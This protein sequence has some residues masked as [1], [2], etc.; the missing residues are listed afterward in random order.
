M[1]RLVLAESVT[2]DDLDDLARQL[3]LVMMNIIPASDAH[4][5]QTIY[6]TRN[7]TDLVHVI[8]DPRAASLIIVVQGLD[9]AETAALLRK[10]V[11]VAAQELVNT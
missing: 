7:R 9:A 11:A 4:P 10:H 5:A 8:D 3:G 1:I 6:R 2:V